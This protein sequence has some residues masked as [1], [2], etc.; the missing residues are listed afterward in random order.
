MYFNYNF[1]WEEQTLQSYI[2]GK[3]IAWKKKTLQGKFFIA[4]TKQPL[5]KKS[6]FKF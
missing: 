2:V 5:K 3:V 1:Y 4:S 6:N